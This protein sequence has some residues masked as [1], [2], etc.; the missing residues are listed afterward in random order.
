LLRAPRALALLLRRTA[1]R[2]ARRSPGAVRAPLFP[3][4]FPTGI[5]FVI[6][7]RLSMLSHGFLWLKLIVCAGLGAGRLQADAPE[8]EQIR[9]QLVESFDGGRSPTAP[10]RMARFA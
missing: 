3:G 1:S 5:L 9:Y 6:A 7:L 2:R 10:S 4:P 8:T